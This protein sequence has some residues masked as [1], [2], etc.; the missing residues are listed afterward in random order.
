MKN[1][2]SNIKKALNFLNKG[3]CVGIPTETVYGLAANAYSSKATAKIFKLKKRPKKNPLIVHYYNL[4][5]LKKD[6]EF[7]ELFL[8]L[9]KKYS[10]GPIT[11]ILRL[12]R[13]SSIS[14][15]VTNNKKTL[16]VRFP[17]HPLTRN[18]LKK[19]KYPLAAPSANIS[20]KISPVSKKD[21]KEEFGSKISFI[22]DGG[23]SKIGVEST[24]IKLVNK[25]QILRL[26][27]IPKNQ[28]TKYFISFGILSPLLSK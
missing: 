3:Q 16:A 15:N 12:N 10:P 24:I 26:G 2:L 19:L 11:F 17:S 18:L 25:P 5:L 8:K 9:Y 27:G 28:I 6:C 7:N 14:K 21:V 22:I 20:T 13:Q 4:K 23:Q 1:N